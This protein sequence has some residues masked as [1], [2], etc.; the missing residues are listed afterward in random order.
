MEEQKD[1]REKTNW[2]IRPIYRLGLLLFS[3]YRGNRVL[4]LNVPLYWRYKIYRSDKRDF[5]TDYL[6]SGNRL[7]HGADCK[8]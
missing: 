7:P 5:A 4:F 6:W 1:T 2:N 3:N 8:F